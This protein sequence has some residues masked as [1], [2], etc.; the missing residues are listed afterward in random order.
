VGGCKAKECN[1]KVVEFGTS[2]DYCSEVY[3]SEV[4]ALKSAVL[5]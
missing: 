4:S 3:S 2:D 5:Y 1:V